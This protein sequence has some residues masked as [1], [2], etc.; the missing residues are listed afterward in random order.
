[1]L[2]TRLQ[3]LWPWALE[4]RGSHFLFFFRIREFWLWDT[5]T[6]CQGCEF[7]YLGN[8]LGKEKGKTISENFH[9]SKGVTFQ[10]HSKVGCWYRSYESWERRQNARSKA[11]IRAD[12][13]REGTERLETFACCVLSGQSRVT[14]W[15]LAQISL[16]A[17]PAHVMAGR[18]M[19]EGRLTSLWALR[20]IHDPVP[21]DLWM[22]FMRVSGA[23]LHSPLLSSW[24]PPFLVPHLQK[25]DINT[26]SPHPT[27]THKF[28]TKSRLFWNCSK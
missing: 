20:Q 9:V 4:N 12:T 10:S 28:I 26:H 6:R 13:S 1:M 16:S 25:A 15:T 27:P 22:H 5:H 21:T 2:T 14:S 3:L 19:A 18:M 23:G 17:M 8:R 7:A 24:E 11:I